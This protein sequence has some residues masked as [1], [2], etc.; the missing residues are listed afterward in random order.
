MTDFFS[1]VPLH[2]NISA[3]VHYHRILRGVVSF[4]LD[5]RDIL[6]EADEQDGKQGEFISFVDCTVLSSCG[7]V[8][9]DREED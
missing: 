1:E 6:S 2:T 3:S 8:P 7:S 4:E 5:P 9:Q